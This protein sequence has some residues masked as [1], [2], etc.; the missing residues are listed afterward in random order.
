MVHAVIKMSGMQH[1][2]QSLPH[3]RSRVVLSQQKPLTSGCHLYK[4]KSDFFTVTLYVTTVS[5]VKWRNLTVGIEQKKGKSLTFYRQ[6]I[7]LLIRLFFPV[8]PAFKGDPLHF[9]LFSVTYIM[10]QGFLWN[11]AHHLYHQRMYKW[12]LSTLNLVLH[13]LKECGYSYYSNLYFWI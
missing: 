2:L 8:W 1:Q 3:K 4:F 10:L 13:D 9:S 7:L 5:L 11:V 12:A 6:S